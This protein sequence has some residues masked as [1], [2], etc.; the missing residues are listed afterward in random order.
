M[1]TNI[2]VDD[3]DTEGHRLN[4]DEAPTVNDDDDTQGH[5]LNVDGQPGY[6]GALTVDPTT[7]S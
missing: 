5:R 2:N 4:S 7:H 3:D 6:S 1:T